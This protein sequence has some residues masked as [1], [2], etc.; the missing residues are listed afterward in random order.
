MQAQKSACDAELNTALHEKMK[1]LCCGA[2]QA[3]VS[4]A[5]TQ[6]MGSIPV[7]ITYTPAS[8]GSETAFTVSVQLPPNNQLSA[9]VNCLTMRRMKQHGCA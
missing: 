8:A 2:M 5:L 6:Y 7:Q 9:Q 1:S 3:D 4:A